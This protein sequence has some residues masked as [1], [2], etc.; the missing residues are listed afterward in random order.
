M[1]ICDKCGSHFPNR[2]LIEGKVRILKSRRFC[3]KCSPFGQHNTRDLTQEETGKPLNEFKT[4]PHC[5]RTLEIQAYFYIRRG[6][7]PSAWCKECTTQNTIER[8][9]ENKR[10]AVEYKGGKCTRC[11]YSK[12]MAALEFHHVGGG[13]DINPANLRSR[14]FDKI[15]PE[16][17]KCILVCGN[18]HREIHEEESSLK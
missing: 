16:L 5:G 10:K 7:R 15:M 17:D 3:L 2:V 11:G 4:C 1:P 13:K 14:R 6:T 9:R 8:M 12:C 18:C